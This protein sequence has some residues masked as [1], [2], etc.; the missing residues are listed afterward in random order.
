MHTGYTTISK[1]I[2]RAT[3]K[4]NARHKITLTMATGL[5]LSTDAQSRLRSHVLQWM[6]GD[7][8]EGARTQ[9]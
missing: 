2:L 4:V 8:C 9:Q 6:G 7:V 1:L 5:V 3:N